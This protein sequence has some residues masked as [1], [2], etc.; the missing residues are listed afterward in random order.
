MSRAI[1]PL[2][3]AACRSA[4]R[5][6]KLFD[7]DG[8][9]LLIQLNGRNPR[10]AL[11]VPRRLPFRAASKWLVDPFHS[12]RSRT[13]FLPVSQGLD[14]ENFIVFRPQRRRPY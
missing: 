5:V 12:R 7:G 14:I 6:Y 2:S 4:K 10:P 1:A 8:L 11:C 3:D 9:Y 13:F